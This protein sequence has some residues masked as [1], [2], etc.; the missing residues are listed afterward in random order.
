V[1]NQKAVLG[2]QTAVMA[3]SRN[4]GLRT[5]AGRPSMDLCQWMMCAS[6]HPPPKK[7]LDL[8]ATAR[9]AGF[10]VHPEL[11]W[12]PGRPT[13]KNFRVMPKLPGW[14]PYHPLAKLSADDVL[15]IRASNEPNERLAQ[16]YGVGPGTIKGVRSGHRARILR[17]K[18]IPLDGRYSVGELTPM[19]FN[20]QRAVGK[21]YLGPI[22]RAI[23]LERKLATLKKTLVLPSKQ[24]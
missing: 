11:R 7:K 23:E 10:A 21:K 2:C 13:H 24:R 22:R 16:P 5:R 15:A 9:Q 17:R 4:R 3:C 14:R 18:V 20:E 6:H 8:P 12:K 1:E 19:M